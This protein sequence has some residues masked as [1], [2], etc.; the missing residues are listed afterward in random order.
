MKLLYNMRLSGVGTIARA[1]QSQ[2]A[3]PYRATGGDACDDFATVPAVD[4]SAC[5]AQA[6]GK[7]LGGSLALP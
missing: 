1:W 5:S 3:S 7:S 4:L 6:D 2:L